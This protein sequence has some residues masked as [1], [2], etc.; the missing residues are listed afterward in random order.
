LGRGLLAGRDAD[1]S[2]IGK[3]VLTFWHAGHPE[4]HTF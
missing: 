2:I 3:V 1:S 4:F